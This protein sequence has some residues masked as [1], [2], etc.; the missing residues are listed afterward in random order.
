VVGATEVECAELVERGLWRTDGNGWRIH[1]WAEYQEMTLSEKR[2]EAGRKGGQAKGKQN[3]VASDTNDEAG[4]SSPVPS[5]PDPDISSSSSSDSTGSS[6]GEE[7]E[8]IGRALK[9]V[10]GRRL[11]STSGVKSPKSW[12]AKVL[13]N[14]RS[15]EMLDVEA[16]RILHEYPEI[17]E[18]QLVDVLEGSTTI[19]RFLNRREDAS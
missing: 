4:P 14:M 19:L 3:H 1:D 17:T 10:V 9:A 2:A 11:A 5:H 13:T 18:G 8:R 7:D 16:A 15:D 6:T 12:T